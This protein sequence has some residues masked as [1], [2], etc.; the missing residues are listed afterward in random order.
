M[1]LVGLLRPLAV[2]V[3]SVDT[4]TALLPCIAH[5]P[6]YLVP[7]HVYNVL[8]SVWCRRS[9]NCKGLFDGLWSKVSWI[10]RVLH[11]RGRHA[12][13]DST[14]SHSPTS[15]SNT[16]VSHHGR[17]IPGVAQHST[18]KSYRVP[19][20]LRYDTDKPHRGNPLGSPRVRDRGQRRYW[21]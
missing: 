15:P 10:V 5:T 13:V 14:I 3:G 11:L 17:H 1:L 7:L 12:T 4:N 9:A 18:R 2:H 16:H 8:G 6:C 20:T 19:S 21:L